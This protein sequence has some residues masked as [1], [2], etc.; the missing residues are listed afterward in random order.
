MRYFTKR[1]KYAIEP[2][3][4]TRVVGDDPSAN[5]K[6]Q[7]FQGKGRVAYT[8]VRRGEKPACWRR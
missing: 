6:R 8:F 3:F 2:R 1:D 7:I 4:F 5:G